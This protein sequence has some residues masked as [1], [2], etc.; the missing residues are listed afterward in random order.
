[1]NPEQNELFRLAMLRVMDANRTRYGLGIVA[2]GHSLRSFGFDPRQFL[3]DVQGFHDA[4]ADALQ[5]FCDK[6]LAEEVG[7]PISAENRAWRLTPKGIALVDQ[8]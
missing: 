8:S 7:K 6:G 1:M 3:G 4:I 5:Y 2:L